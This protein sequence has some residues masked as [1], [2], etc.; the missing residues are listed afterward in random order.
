VPIGSTRLSCDCTA[1]LA[2][3]PASRAQL[4]ISSKPCSISGTSCA[5]SSFMKLGSE[6]DSMICAPRA[7]GST[8]RITARTRSPV[9][10]FS[11]AII[12]LRFRRPS[13]RPDS[14][15]RSP[16]SARLTV[17]TKI[18]SPRDMKSL[19]SCSRSASRIFCR[20]TCLA[21][22]APMRPIGTESIGSSM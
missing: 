21:A 11:L 1:I 13:T 14:T 16:L 22:C 4:L 20:I 5:N 7:V 10:R 9:R 2:R 8:P 15:M 6:R 12:S 17:P 19:S 3:E 18:L